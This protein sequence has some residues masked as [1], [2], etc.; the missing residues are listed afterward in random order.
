[1]D[2]AFFLVG[3]HPNLYL[4]ISC[5]PPSQLLKHFPRLPEIGRKTL[6]GSDWPGP[7]VRGIKDALDAFRALPLPEE[8]K[9]HILSRTALAI[10]P[11]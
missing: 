10:W 4:D 8:S 9:Q 5:L 7:G 2:T 6:I 1:M 11:P 3:G